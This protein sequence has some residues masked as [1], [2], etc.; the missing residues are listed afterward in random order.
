M[1]QSSENTPA[2]FRLQWPALFVGIIALAICA[3]GGLFNHEQFFRS[4]LVGYIFALG[5]ALGSMAII[6]VNHLTGGGWGLLIRRSGEAAAGTLPLLFVMFIPIAFGLKHLY[7][8]ARPE[9]LA[10]NPVLKHRQPLLNP[11]FF[12]IRVLIYFAIWIFWGWRLRKLSLRH[13]ID[14]DPAIAQRLAALSAGGL[15]IYFLTMSLAAMD[16]MVSREIHWYSSIFGFMVIVGQ[17]LSATTFMLIILSKLSDDPPLH[18]AAEPDLIHDLGNL[19]LTQVI[20]WAYISLAQM[21]IIW[22]GNEQEEI[23]WYLHRSQGI[24]LVVAVMLI[25]LHFFVPFLLLLIQGAKRNIKILATIAAGV[26]ILRFIDVVWIIEPSSET[27][28]AHSLHWMDFLAPIGIG[29][30]WFALF[31]WILKRHPLIPMGERIEV[32]LSHGS[33]ASTSRPTA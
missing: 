20:L 22:M 3:I 23:T 29:G 30:I 14:G 7:P 27:R 17:A 9:T 33:H 10:A 18:E 21:L 12:L 28:I 32:D 5:L 15:V 16:W 25:V 26:L 19:F 2:L 1:T 4:Y 6:M 13:D 8:W 24:W 31:L 11:E